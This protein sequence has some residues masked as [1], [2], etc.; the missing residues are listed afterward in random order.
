MSFFSSLFS[1]STI[2]ENASKIVDG[3][4]SGLD[5]IVLTDEEKLSYSGKF[6]QSKIDFLKATEPYKLAQRYLAF[7]IIINFF[8]AFWVGV[9]TYFV[10][11]NYLEGY[12]HLVS[13]FELGWITLAVVAFYFKPEAISSLFSKGK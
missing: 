13:T 3:A 2:T 1:T 4:I 5:A 7:F 11:P 6:M 9:I 12:I 10:F 8:I